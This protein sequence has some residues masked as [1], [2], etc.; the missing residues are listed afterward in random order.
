MADKNDG[1][2]FVW[3]FFGGLLV[4]LAY[5]KWWKDD[6]PPRPPAPVYSSQPAYPDG[7]LASLDN[8]TVWRMVWGSV[9]GPRDARLAWVR[10]DHSKNKSVTA[11]ET[12]TLYTV[13]CET[14]GF[15]A[16]SIVEYDK[17]GKVLGQWGDEI[18]SKD[19]DYAPPGSYI[20][21]VVEGACLPRFDPPKAIPAPI[22]QL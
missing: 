20:E 3:L 4:W 19:Y 8:G 16:L 2:W 7:P 5:D 21:N 13:N 22:G 15:R 10:A 9:K 1:E 11:R 14:T 17:D 6:E 18:L 12:M